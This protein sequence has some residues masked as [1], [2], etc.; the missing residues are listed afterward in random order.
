MASPIEDYALI[1]DCETAAL[2][3]R[4]GSIDWLCW[5]RFD[6]PACFAALVGDAGNGRWRIAPSSRIVSIS[7]AY[8][9]GSLVLETIYETEDGVV[10]LVDFMP[11][12]DKTCHVVRIVE[13][14]SGR[15]RMTMEL[16]LR[17]DYGVMTPW[18]TRAADGALHA[19]AG[20]DMA[21]L[22]TPV[23]LEGRDMTTVAQ[24]EVAAKDRV[25]FVLSFAPSHLAAPDAIDAERE[26]KRTEAAWR[27][28][29]KACTVDGPYVEAVARSLITLKAL[30]H[31][32]TGGT[33]AA[34]TTSL[35]EELGGERNWD[36][37]YCWI[38]DATFLLLALMSAG[39]FEEAKAWTAWLHRAVAGSPQDMQI[40]YSVTGERRLTEWEAPWLSG[41]EGS[42]PVR[43]GNA[44]H[45]QLQIDVFGELMD[46][47]H[48]AR[49]NGLTDGDTW[50]LQ[51]KIMDHVV[52]IWNEPDQ[53]MWEVRGPPRHFTFSKIM[54]WVAIDRAIQDAETFGLEGPVAMWRTLCDEIYRDVCANGINPATG[55]FQRAY[56]DP[57]ADAS[58]LLVAELGFVAADDPRFAATV[59]AVERELISAEGLVQRYDTLGAKDGLPPGEGAF[60]P[61]SFWLANAYAMLGRQAEA[62]KLFERLLEFRN[63]V[64][65]LAEEFDPRTGR[66]TGNFPQA[67]S[68]I[69]LIGA[70]LN[71]THAVKPSQVRAR[72]NLADVSGRG[73]A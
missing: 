18:V 30:S 20:P 51:R 21:V 61:C 31:T 52:E 22:R 47:T 54:A 10:A 9:P 19:V 25:P 73:T 6:S 65:L 37:R 12:R 15:V 40:M 49:I 55:G 72:R 7:R 34:P 59:A 46:A 45:S 68:H 39:H 41:Y 53:G 32:P 69:G 62:T 58:L 14:R 57:G 35:P 8:R 48:Q 28:W 38:R 17:F 70:A 27:K 43:I 33:V 23:D 29:L 11:L 4:D 64:G 44:A 60:L 67:L 50:A 66:L 2:V 71:L 42:Q 63:D 24:F 56:D 26:L 3:G 13:G 36:Y 16:V 5:R 1:G